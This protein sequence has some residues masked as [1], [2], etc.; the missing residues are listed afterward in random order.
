MSGSGRF[1]VI[2]APG[3]PRHLGEAPS[4]IF[5][6]IDTANDRHDLTLYAWPSG[7]CRWYLHHGDDRADALDEL[8]E[9]LE[10]L[11]RSVEDWFR[12]A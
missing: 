8:G 10:V 3:V 2:S 12:S 7:E 1:R 5:T 6:L 4:R 9:G 11:R